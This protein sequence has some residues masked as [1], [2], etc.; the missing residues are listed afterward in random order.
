MNANVTDSADRFQQ[1]AKK[2]SA[3][4]WAA[5]R[6]EEAQL[7]AP[8]PAPTAGADAVT[9]ATAGAAA[10]TAARTESAAAS[11]ALR[12]VRAQAALKHQLGAEAAAAAA[13]AAAGGGRGGRGGQ[14]K[15]Q[16][17]GSGRKLLEAVGGEGLAANADAGAAAGVADIGSSGVHVTSAG[18]GAGNRTR[19]FLAAA[20]SNLD[21]LHDRAIKWCQDALQA[22]SNGGNGWH[23]QYS[24]SPRKPATV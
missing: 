22:V 8:A 4:D 20:S 18:A 17:R 15:A 11:A 19:R 1:S 10:S 9:T 2:L 21:K 6:F 12:Q 16:R 14:R 23:M 24:A 5:T 3:C 7:I 13:A